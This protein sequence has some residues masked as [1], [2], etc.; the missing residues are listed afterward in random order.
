MNVPTAIINPRQA[1]DF[2][3][4]LGQLAKTDMLDADNL[5]RFGESIQPVP[6]PLKDA[7]TQVLSALLTRRRQLVDMLVA[8]KNR[9]SRS[10]KHVQKDVKAHIRWLEKRLK[11]V[12][13]KLQAWVQVSPLWQ[14]KNE[15]LQSAPGVGQ[16]F[17][18]TVLA[19][20][21]E[22]G[23]LNR[24]QI[25]AMVGVAPLNRDSGTCRGQRRVW[26]GRRHVRSVLY[27][28]TLAA[29]R[30]NP[31]IRPFYHRLILSGKKP[32]VAIVACMRKFLTILNAMMRDEASW[33]DKYGSVCG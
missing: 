24:K 23:Q 16:T 33:N 7:Q 30:C 8:E 32:K 14:V 2:A 4:A 11:D 5:A 25:A 12:D 18:I 28:A 1:R 17:S 6:R 20:L 26:G 15:R 10:H 13:T 31:V 27:M 29:I 3:R 19:E 9:L 22:L 21:P